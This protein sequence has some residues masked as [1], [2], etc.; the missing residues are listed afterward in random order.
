[1]EWLVRNAVPFVLVFT[2]ADKETPAAVQANIAA[3]M[4]RIAGWFEK[5][6]ASF[7]CSAVA[8][9]G[10]QDL[11][12]VIDEAMTAINAESKSAAVAADGLPGPGRKLKPTRKS[13]PDLARPW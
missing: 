8:Q 9:Q 4:A 6:P 11:L 1:M 5:P 12:G 10:R 13:R 2:K 3:F 7:T